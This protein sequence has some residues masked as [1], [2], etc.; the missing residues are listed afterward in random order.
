MM[1]TSNYVFLAR[2]LWLG[3]LVGLCSVVFGQTVGTHYS[4]GSIGFEGITWMPN[5]DIFTVDYYAGSVYRLK[6][7]GS[8]TTIASGLGNVAGG[9]ADA[10]GN[11]YFS[12]FSTG[13][14]YRVRP[15]GQYNLFVSGL[16]TPAA[17]H[18]S[19][20][21][22]FLYVAEFD[23]SRV[24]KINLSNKS[25]THI[26]SGNGML[27]VDGITVMANGDILA[28]SFYNRRIT[29]IKL[30]G[31]TSLFGMHPAAGFMGYIAR[32]GDYYYVPSIGGHNIARFDSLG[33]SEIIAGTGVKGL[34]NGAA[35]LAQFDSPNGIIA[36]AAGDTL[37][38][39][40][41]G[42]IRFI[43]GLAMST[44]I[45]PDLQPIRYKVYPSP[46]A[47]RLKLDYTLAPNTSL[48]VEVMNLSGQ[49]VASFIPPDTSLQTQTYEFEL[50]DLPAGMYLVNIWENESIVSVRKVRKR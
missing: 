18:L 20:D 37:L 17:L 45:E 49:I 30:D 23:S 7:D 26:A 29:R 33:N 14:V 42:Q 16:V 15:D 44:D 9:G 43:T 50:G 27:G 35:D 19:A 36:N 12:V 24:S 41:A 32:A 47:E 22:N 25:V 31:S 28:A 5:G 38:V 1:M 21:S 13:K 40:E 2:S 3:L 39:T 11:Y 10:D 48:K 34:V 8:I 4:N 6:P 46:F